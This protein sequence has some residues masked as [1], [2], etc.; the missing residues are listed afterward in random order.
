MI[1]NLAT[2]VVAYGVS[3]RLFDFAW[4]GQLRALYPS[5]TA[6]QASFLHTDLVHVCKAMQVCHS[7]L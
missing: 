7:A 2:L 3:H 4:K 5:A 1:M 6:Y